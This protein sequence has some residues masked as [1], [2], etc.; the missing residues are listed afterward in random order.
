VTEAATLESTEVVAVSTSEATEVIAVAAPEATETPIPAVASAPTPPSPPVPPATITAPGLPLETIVGGLLILLIVGYVGFYW[1]GL[2][3]ADRYEAGFMIHRCPVCRR[4]DLSLESHQDRIL[5]VPRARRT[6]RCD[7]CRSVLREAG[8]RRWRYAV[9]RLE[10]PAMFDLYNNRVIDESTLK[11]LEDDPSKLSR[12]PGTRPP[13][14][15]PS[16]VDDDDES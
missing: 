5:G 11:K 3:A 12:P 13:A 14:L 9:D 7:D 4:G 15:P 10:N 2:V 6:V 16:F 1:R 8:N